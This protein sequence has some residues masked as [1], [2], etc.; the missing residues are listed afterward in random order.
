ME[1][2]V[3]IHLH[4]NEMQVENGVDEKTNVECD[5]VI[6][7]NLALLLKNINEGRQR[8]LITENT[9]IRRNER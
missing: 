3:G 6:A 1:P 9:E 8:K 5:A 2:G 4:Y 7:S